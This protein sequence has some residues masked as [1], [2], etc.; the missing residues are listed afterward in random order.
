[1][2]IQL[3]HGDCLDIM[4]Q[5]PDGSVDLV[6]ADPPYGID[7]QSARRIDKAQWKPKIANDAKPFVSWLQDCRRIVAQNGALLCFCRWDVQEAFKT[8]IE[9]AGF[10]IK[11]QVIWDKVVHGMGDLDGA[12]APQ[13]EIIWF[14]TKSG[15][16]FPGKRPRSVITVKRVAAEKLL[17][18]NEKP[19]ELMVHLIRAT[20]QAGDMVGDWFLGCGTTGVACVKTGRNFIGIEIDKGYYDIAEKRIREAEMQPV[21]L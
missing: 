19:I 9:A 3:I 2:T 15:F 1:M 13:H 21:L 18:P 6:L 7:Y 17:H 11:S 20:T 4:L 5:I 14:A 8:S 12:F 10:T 16:K